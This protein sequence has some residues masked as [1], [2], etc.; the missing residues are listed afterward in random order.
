VIGAAASVR[1]HSDSEH[2]SRIPIV[3]SVHSSLA[4]SLAPCLALGNL[5]PKYTAGRRVPLKMRAK[6]PQIRNF[7]SARQ[8]EPHKTETS[9]LAGGLVGRLRGTWGQGSR[10]ETNKEGSRSSH[11]K[12]LSGKTSLS[13]EGV[14]ERTHLKVQQKWTFEHY[15]T[16]LRVRVNLSPIGTKLTQSFATITDH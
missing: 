12:K 11:K 4:S 3:L 1:G 8:A 6:A 2:D 10:V 16:I 9:E 14:V 15:C 5:T 13:M 7:H